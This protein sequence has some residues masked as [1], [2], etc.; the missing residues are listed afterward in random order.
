[1]HLRAKIAVL[2]QRHKRGRWGHNTVPCRLGKAIPVTRRAREGIGSPARC[3]DHTVKALLALS[4]HHAAHALS[5]KEQVTH[6]G[7][8]DLHPCLAARAHQRI[9]DIG[10]LV[11]YRKHA[12]AALH[13]ER[14][15]DLLKKRL[16]I[17]GAE[18]IP[19]GKQKPRIARNVCKKH[20]TCAMICYVASTL[21]G[22]AELTAATVIFFKHGNGCAKT[23]GV[24][25][26]H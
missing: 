17:L 4:G 7:L 22:N 21:A 3:H 9:Y 6:N 8:H 20:V 15:T 13:L 12:I 19:R 25:R 1:M 24:Y 14:H 2:Y 11:G 23:R 16:G 26:R 5:L 10:R 18:A